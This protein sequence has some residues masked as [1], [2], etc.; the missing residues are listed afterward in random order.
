MLPS[1]ATRGTG[2][3]LR[4]TTAAGWGQDR[5]PEAPGGGLP[6][7]EEQNATGARER[8]AHE[9]E[10]EDRGHTEGILETRAATLPRK[11]QGGIGEMERRRGEQSLLEERGHDEHCGQNR[12]L[13]TRG[14]AGRGAGHRTSEKQGRAG[15]AGVGWQRG[16]ADGSRSQCSTFGST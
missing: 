5:P 9:A 15:E 14:Q 3:V 10:A 7:E 1:E 6:G 13:E 2:H 16:S 12:R 4:G 11:E 8:D